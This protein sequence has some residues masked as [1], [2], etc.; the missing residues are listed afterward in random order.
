MAVLTNAERTQ[1]WRG[2]MRYW[3]RQNNVLPNVDKVQLRTAIDETDV[4]IDTHGGNVSL[5]TIGYNGAISDPFK[6]NASL[7][8]KT[9]LFCG[10]AA[11]RV[12]KAFAQ[13]L[14]GGID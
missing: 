4:W 14:F 1:V 11:R 5:D 8:Q 12:S 9:E 2:I 10:V 7:Q 13:Q 6:T 3:S